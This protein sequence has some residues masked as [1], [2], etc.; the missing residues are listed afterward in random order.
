MT[1]ALL[2]LGVIYPKRHFVIIV[3]LVPTIRTLGLTLRVIVQTVLLEDIH[4]K[5]QIFAIYVYT[6]RLVNPRRPPMILAMNVLLVLMA[7]TEP[8]WIVLP[9]FFLTHTAPRIVKHVFR[10]LIIL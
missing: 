4:L 7:T 1:I 10:A 8:A 2:G 3:L 5:S 6:G 9:A